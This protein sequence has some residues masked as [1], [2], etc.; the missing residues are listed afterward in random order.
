MQPIPGIGPSAQPASTE[1]A[2]PAILLCLTEDL[3]LVPRLIDVA[4]QVGLEPLVI[5][6]AESLGAGGQASAR[7]VPLTE[8][9]EGPDAAFVRYVAELQ[10]ALVLVDLASQS[11]PGIRWVQ[12]LKTSAATRRIPVVAFGPHVAREALRLAKQAGADLVVP[13]SRLQAS[14][15]AILTRMARRQDSAAL[16]E[17]CSQ[18][19]PDRATRAIRLIAEGAYFEAHEEL[20]ALIRARSSLDTTLYRAL[21]QVSVAYLQV[22][23]G[24]FRGAVKMLLRLHQWLDPLPPICQGVDVGRLRQ[25]IGRLRRALEA[26]GPTGISGLDPSLLAPAR[27]VEPSRPSTA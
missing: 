23:R 14:L 2:R 20:E 24:N 9:L 6:T 5:E 26:V 3:F 11:V 10:P 18:P 27:T 15:P 16:A 25:D 7:R 13:R 19:L 8:P 4:R 12:V 22:S 21:L 1:P 17:A